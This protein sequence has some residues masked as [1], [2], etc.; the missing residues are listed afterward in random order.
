VRWVARVRGVD[1]DRVDGRLAVAPG[2]GYYLSCPVTTAPANALSYEPRRQIDWSGRPC[3]ASRPRLVE[4]RDAPLE[5]DAQGCRWA[6]GLCSSF[7]DGR[8][9]TARRSTISAIQNSIQMKGTHPRR[10]ATS[11]TAI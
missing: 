6:R 5:V 9:T 4:E 3:T 10:S 8:S 2:R 11:F 7:A 1:R